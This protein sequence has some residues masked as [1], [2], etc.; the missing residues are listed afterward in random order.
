MSHEVTDFAISIYFWRSRSNRSVQQ[1]RRY[2]GERLRR[3]LPN[4]TPPTA[5]THSM[6]NSVRYRTLAGYCANDL[7]ARGECATKSSSY[8]QVSR[9]RCGPRARRA[10]RRRG[11][12]QE[13]PRLLPSNNRL[14]AGEHVLSGRGPGIA[15]DAGVAPRELEPRYGLQL[16]LPIVES[17]ATRRRLQ[18]WTT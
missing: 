15:V 13:A 18:K 2:Q 8:R 9:H 7:I 14:W 10:H 12:P 16:I 3:S 11:R 1:Q 6:R 17:P 4:E 5:L